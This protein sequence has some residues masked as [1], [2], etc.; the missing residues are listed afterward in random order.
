MS[1][2]HEKR[3]RGLPPTLAMAVMGTVATG[4][5][6]VVTGGVATTVGTTGV[7]GLGLIYALVAVA[8]IAFSLASSAV[9]SH[10]GIAAGLHTYVARGLG[11]RLGLGVAVLMAVSYAALSIS[12]FGVIGFE[13]QSQIREHAQ[14]AV[15]WVILVVPFVALVGFLGTR[16]LRTGAIVTVGVLGVVVAAHFLFDFTAIAH[17]AP[18]G[19]STDTLDPVTLFTGAIGAAVGFS[20]TAYPG[21]ETPMALGGE[22]RATSRQVTTA[23]YVAVIVAGVANVIAALTVTS[24]L[25][26][27][28]LA[29]GTLEKGSDPVFDFLTNNLGA[30]PAGL[31]GVANLVA[32]FGAALVLHQAAARS[33]RSLAAAGVL[34]PAFAVRSKRNGAPLNASL[35]Q[36][37]VAIVVLLAFAIG[38]ADP[39]RTLFV[40]LSNIGAVGVFLALICAAGAVMVFLLR[41]DSEGGGFLGW[42]GKLVAA[43]VAALCI[44][45][46]LL[47]AL[48]ASD[49]R[50]DV[51]SGS[52]AAAVPSLVVI[53][54][55]FTGVLCPAHRRTARSLA[56]DEVDEHATPPAL[57]PGGGDRPAAPSGTGFPTGSYPPPTASPV[58]SPNGGFPVRNPAFHHPP[59]VG[60]PYLPSADAPPPP[61]RR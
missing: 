58:L 7:I 55:I 37:G 38:G 31:F 50:L 24:A 6:A 57:A 19:F 9:V 5:L 44:G 3:E 33:M 36:S 54:A 25:G 49:V 11:E 32:V 40:I 46:V 41:S 1:L 45:A 13:L 10:T 2:P 4:P 48:L 27:Q 39:F 29:D 34:P 16:S 61:P 15:P 14:Y 30:G 22:L 28:T 18:G 26:P 17:P 53:A 23:A 59:A 8:L 12:Y 42:E 35:L 60:R 51:P 47:S 52:F 21:I 56:L 20:V 43:V